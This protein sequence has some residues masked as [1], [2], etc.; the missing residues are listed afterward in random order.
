MSREQ[1]PFQQATRGRLV[2]VNYRV[3]EE[4]RDAVKA[5]AVD[6]YGPNGQSEFVRRALEAAVVADTGLLEPTTRPAGPPAPLGRRKP[7]EGGTPVDLALLLSRWSGL[8]KAILV[9]RIEAGKVTMNGEVVRD[10]F[11]SFVGSRDQ[12]E[13]DGLPV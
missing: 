7:E 8:P 2:Q 4:L 10:Q 9:R 12:F 1:S 5:R 13:L 3:P 11:V 6:L